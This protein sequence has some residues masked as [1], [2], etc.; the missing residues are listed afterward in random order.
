M[1][2]AIINGQQGEFSEGITVLAA[3]KQLGFDIPTLCNDD[4]LAPVGSCRMCLVEVKGSSSEVVSCKTLLFEG[5]EVETHGALT[6]TARIWNLRMLAGNYPAEAFEAFPDKPFHKLASKYGLTEA[7]FCGDKVVIDNSHTYIAVDMA[8]CINCYA[9][10]RICADVQGQFVWH[11]LGRGEESQILPDSFGAFGDSTCVSCGACSDACPTGA[12]EDKTV[13]ERGFPTTWT[14]TTCPYCGT[15]CEMNVGVRDD[16][17]VQVK[18]VMDAP[19]N[20]GHLCVKGRYAYDFVDANDRVT[21]PMI[22]EDDGWK[23]VSWEE[24]ISYAAHKLKEIDSE[25]GRDSIAV[26]GSARA[27]NEENYLAQKFTR[28]VLGTN[29]VDCCARV[30]HTPSAAAMKIMIGTGAMTNSF[31]DIEKAKTI[32]LC[33]ANPTENHPIPGARIKQAV[34]KNGTKLIVID[35]RKTELTKYADVHLQLRPGTNILMFNAL[36][37]T[38]IDEGLTDSE[39]IRTRVTEYDEFRAFVAEYS[40]EAVAARCGVDAGLIRKAARI[41]AT[42]TPSMAMHG[43]GM[44]EHLQGTEGVMSIVNLALLTGN[45]GKHG[46]GVNPLRGQN[47]VQGSAHM[48]CDPGILTGS[49]TIETGRELFESVWKQPVP[50]KAGLNQLQMIDAARDGKLKA[51]WTIGYD[52]FLSNANAHETAKAFANMDLVII[53]DFFMNE[54][55]KQ[56]GHVFFPATTSF[57]KDGTFMNGERRVQRIRAAVSPR[58]NAKSDLEIICDLAAAMG[59]EKD[60]AF[61]TAEGVWDEVRAVWPPGYGITYERIEKAG[62]QWPCPDIDHPGTEVLHGESF[63]NGVAAALKRIKYRPTKE[64]V[65]DDF[66]FMLTTGRV[67]EQFNAGTMTMRTPNKE[68]R[69]TD[70]LQ[71][72]KADSQRLSIADGEKVR[73][74]SNYGEAVLPVEITNKVKTGELFASFHDPA[75]FLNYATGPTRDRF[76][77]APEFKVTAVR[78]EKLVESH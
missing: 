4:R 17:V 50:T 20:Y 33:G 41:Y 7:D 64:V 70:L 11:V 15:G 22:R 59:F 48:G 32:I 76:T 13:I 58:G 36:A 2:R 75:V 47:N 77:Q 43:L 56:F 14:K 28:V 16:R 39:F 51:L 40:P 5:M 57:E 61:K 72:S 34:I 27:T 78:I 10:V 37:Y 6:E 54:T 62:I 68:L 31:D 67:L 30:C 19:V 18:P 65:T 29:N 3:A 12:L 8:R 63:S 46:A 42:N 25:F 44:T 21:E 73:L 9:C 23:V 24:A 38:I 60:F 35:P 55:A 71:M 53:Q 74:L 1:I 52:V 26:L 69:P 49:V 66:P 45:I